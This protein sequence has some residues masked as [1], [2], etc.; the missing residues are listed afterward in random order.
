MAVDQHVEKPELEK[1]ADE[2]AEES[3]PEGRAKGNNQEEVD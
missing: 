3:G 1:F 2:G